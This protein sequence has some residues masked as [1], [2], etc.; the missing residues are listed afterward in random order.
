MASFLEYAERKF[1]ILSKTLNDRLAEPK[2]V[3]TIAGV[4]CRAPLD[5]LLKFLRTATVASAVV[6]AIDR[7]EWDRSR[8]AISSEQPDYFSALARIFRRLGRPELG[9]AP[10]RALISAA[11]SQHWHVPGIGLNHLSNVMRLGRMSGTKAVLRFLAS[12][13][14]PAEFP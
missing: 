5:S 4:A 13:K 10:A 14:F 8:L 9:E 3:N 1:S 6:S 7:G 12:L 2:A 11:E